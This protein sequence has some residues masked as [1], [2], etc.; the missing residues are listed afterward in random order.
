M[1]HFYFKRLLLSM[2][3]VVGVVCPQ[4]SFAQG[5]HATIVGKI[6]DTK[7][8]TVIGATVQVRNESTGFTTGVATNANGDYTIQQIPL[9]TPYTI[10]AKYVGYGDQKKSGYTLN[11]GDMLRVNFVMKEEA[12]TMDEVQVV[13]NSLRKSVS[14]AGAATVISAKNIA[15][16]P[17]NGRNFT[18]LIDL[19]PLSAGSSL[20]GQLSTSTNFTIDGMTA[21]NPTSGGTTNRNGGPYSISMEAVR[22]FEVVT[23]QYDVTFGRSGGGTVSTVTKSGT[24]TTKGSAFL[25]S[26]ANWLSSPYNISGT[27]R[28][29]KFSTYQ[30][31]ASLGGAIVKDRA[32]YFVAWDHQEDSRPLYIADIKSAADE[33]RLNLTQ[34]TLDRFL[35]IARSKYGVASTPQTG[36]FDKKQGTD[37]VFARI[38]WQLNPTN[39]LTI[40]DNYVND[41]NKQKLDDNTTIN[42]YEV[43]GDVNSVDNSLLATLRTVFSPKTVNELKLQ[44]L[45]TSE[46]STPNEQLSQNNIPRAIIQNIPSEVNGKTVYTN[47]QLGGQRYSPENFYNNVVH[48]VDNLYYNTKRVNYTFGMD[49]MYSNMNSRYGSEANGRFYYLGLDAFENNQPYRYAREIYMTKDERVKQDIVNSGVYAQLQ[50][51]LFK[52]FEVM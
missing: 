6:T 21:K 1:K 39:L 3:V 35:K 29:V 18:S 26:R 36:S 11:Q 47:I 17:V 10:T 48:L 46:E 25:F 32:H 33:T 23:N 30:Y 20:G 37:A 9:G 14:N 8:E 38:D 4:L 34:T 41:R 13:A 15:V 7:G 44:H 42:L 28:D 2:I 50:T 24:N 45:Y 40:R 16:L 43:Y 27:K 31:G 12:V 52:G 22:E 5:T 19:S 49:M 51:K